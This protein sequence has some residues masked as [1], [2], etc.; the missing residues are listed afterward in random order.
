MKISK[1]A[2]TRLSRYRQVLCRLKEIGLSRVVSNNLA[3]AAEVSA[4]QVRKDFSLYEIPGNKRG[5]YQVD[6]LIEKL[7]NILGKNE[8]Q[9]AILIGA[10]KIGKALMEYKGFE[11]EGIKI[12]AAF[13]IDPETF[14]NTIPILPLEKLKEFVREHDIKLAII[15]VP[16]IAAQQATDIAVSAGIIGILNFAPIRLRKSSNVVVNNVNLILEIEKL[17]YWVNSLHT[18]KAEKA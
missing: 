13:D 18:E 5:G 15:T 1:N 2:I 7:D 12:F 9:K 11:K 16:A 8:V 6:V 14:D 3:D 10:G 4:L 17:I